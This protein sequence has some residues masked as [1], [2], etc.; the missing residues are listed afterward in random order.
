METVSVQLYYIL[1]VMLAMRL[2]KLRM[3]TVQDR[4][5]FMNMA[6]FKGISEE[7]ES[8]FCEREKRLF[9]GIVVV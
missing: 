3:S 1:L 6:Y 2:R 8:S 5:W 9:Q 4:M 7:N